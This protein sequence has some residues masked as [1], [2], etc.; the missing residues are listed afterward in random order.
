MIVLMA[1]L[2][3]TG[4]STLAQALASTL[5]GLVIDKDSVRKAMFSGFVDYT[6]EQDDAAMESVFSAVEYV[7]RTHPHVPVFIDGCT[8]ARRSQIARALDVAR[9]TDAPWHILETVCSD[10]TARNRL[11]AGAASNAHP[12]ANRTFALYQSLKSRREPIV[13]PKFVVNTERPLELCLNE[14]LAYLS[15]PNA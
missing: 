4:K 8:F 9:N 6:R 3:A 2:P 15:R 1:G 13:E 5:K 7:A 11:E 14:C 12:A 10:E